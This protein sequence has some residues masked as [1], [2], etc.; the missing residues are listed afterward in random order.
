MIWWRDPNTRKS[1]IHGGNMAIT[2]DNDLLVCND[3][4]SYQIFSYFLDIFI[5][6]EVFKEN[7]DSYME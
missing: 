7:F 6:F 2:K 5:I 4:Y 3:Q 1:V